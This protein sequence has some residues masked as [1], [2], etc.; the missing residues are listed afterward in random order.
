M[1]EIARIVAMVTTE[2]R[3]IFPPCQT[4]IAGCIRR[5][6]RQNHSAGSVGGCNRS[7]GSCLHYSVGHSLCFSCGARGRSVGGVPQGDANRWEE[8]LMLV[9]LTMMSKC[10]HECFEEGLCV[11]VFRLT[12]CG[13]HD[14]DVVTN[15]AYRK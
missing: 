8:K 15:C 5:T 11:S 14:Y 2:R 10:R 7:A 6:V 13:L 1:N 3:N 12:V 4:V 9:C